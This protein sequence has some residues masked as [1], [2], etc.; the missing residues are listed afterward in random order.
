[1]VYRLNNIANFT[2][3]IFHRFVSETSIATIKGTVGIYT[4]SGKHVSDIG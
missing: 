3:G 4:K 2:K 1:M